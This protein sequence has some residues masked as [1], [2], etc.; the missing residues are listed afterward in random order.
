[1]GLLVMGGGEVWLRVAV[2]V[3]SVVSGVVD[4][5]VS[6]TSLVILSDNLASNL[7]LITLLSSSFGS[8]LA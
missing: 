7:S 3:R 5:R 6:V 1:M 8:N 4:L 2:E